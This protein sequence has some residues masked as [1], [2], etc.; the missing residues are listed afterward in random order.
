MRVVGFDPALHSSLAKAQ[1][2]CTAVALVNWQVKETPAQFRDG[3]QLYEMV[4]S[5]HSKVE[6]SPHKHFC[7]PKGSEGKKGDAEIEIQ[8]LA[9]LDVNQRVAVTAK[10]LRLKAVASICKNG[11]D[12]VMQEATVADATG[13]TRM[14]MWGSDVERLEAEKC[15][16]VS[17]LIVKVYQGAKYLSLSDEA[18]VEQI[19]DLGEVAD[20]PDEGDTSNDGI[21]G[22]IVG[23]ASVNEFTSCLSCKAKVNAVGESIGQCTKCGLKVKLS[24]CELR[25]SAR[26]VFEAVSGGQQNLTIFGKELEAIKEKGSGSSLEEQLLSLP[27]IKVWMSE[28]GIVYSVT[29]L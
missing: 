11:R 1:A 23:V 13:S 16:R 24:K 29:V 4:G 21:E 26:V 2:D 28:K 7:A 12:L 3:E 9:T 15:F 22:E 5:S 25:I 14:V 20:V 18:T 6:E 10:V 17:G 8:E 27:P 19:G